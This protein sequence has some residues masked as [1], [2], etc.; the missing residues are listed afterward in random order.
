VR[1]AGGPAPGELQFRQLLQGL[2]PPVSEVHCVTI[3]AVPTKVHKLLL[4]QASQTA[5]NLTLAVE[6]TEPG[7]VIDSVEDSSAQFS[8][9]KYR[10]PC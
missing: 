6:W 5:A 9:E 4:H 7:K 3:F 2:D 1:G 10:N 8:A